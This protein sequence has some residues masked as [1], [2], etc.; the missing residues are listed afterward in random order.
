MSAKT[1][2]GEPPN[3]LKFSVVNYYTIVFKL[4]IN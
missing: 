1:K 2:V 3:L 4:G